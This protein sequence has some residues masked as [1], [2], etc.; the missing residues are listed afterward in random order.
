MV[1][2]SKA[3]GGDRPILYKSRD[4][5]KGERR[6]SDNEDWGLRMIPDEFHDSLVFS[7]DEEFCQLVDILDLKARFQ[8]DE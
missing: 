7:E 5:M 1:S 4:E 3:R 8:F 6:L 2:C